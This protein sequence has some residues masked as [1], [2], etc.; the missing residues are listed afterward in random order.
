MTLGGNVTSISDYA[1]AEC[2]GLAG[3]SLPASLNS[4]GNYVFNDCNLLTA[5]NV[6]A[7]NLVYSSVTGVLFNKSQTTLILYPPGKAGS[8]SIPNSVTTIASSAFY[9]CY[10]LTGVTIGNNVINIG[11]YA[12]NYCTG[13]PSVT[14]GS[15]VTTIGYLVFD[16]CTGLTAINVNVANLFFSSVAGVLFDKSQTMLIE[17]PPG[18]GGSYS[19]PNSTTVIGNNAFN[20]CTLAAVMIP[21]SVTNLGYATFYGCTSLSSATIGNGV[22]GIS[23]DTF[24]YC[25]NL[26]SIMIPSSVTYIESSAFTFAGLTSVTIPDSMTSIG[27]DAFDNSFY[28]TN[29]IIGNGV[30]KIGTYAFYNCTSLTNVTIGNNLAVIGDGAFYY[31]PLLAGVYFKGNAPV[32]GTDIFYGDNIVTNYY[33]AMA[34][35]WGTTLGGRPTALW[36]LP[37]QISIGGSGVRTN[38]FGF[39]IAGSAGLVVVVEACTNLVN[40]VWL[41]VQTNTLT[42]GPAYF[43]DQQWTNYPRR[44]YRVRSP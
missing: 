20:Y 1:F 42:G 19:I 3:V 34:T 18:K 35:G 4:L 22:P 30:T 12:F 39:N 17:Y 9:A 36:S 32:V 10:G 29:V 2:D 43:S 6:D 5:I 41:P 38:R 11:D 26:T 25:Y 15:G 21:G 44:F 33:L 24:A 28:L 16:E 14:L 23:Y 27:N 37:V 40:H 13:L 8:Y 7:A 31:C